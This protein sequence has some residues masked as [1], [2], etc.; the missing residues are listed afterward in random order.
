MDPNGATTSDNDDYMSDTYTAVDIRP[1]FFW[2]LYVE[3]DFKKILNELISIITFHL[4][5]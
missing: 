2:I 4:S 3:K 1:G 5:V